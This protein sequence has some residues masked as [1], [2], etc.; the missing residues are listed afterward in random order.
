MCAIHLRGAGQH[1][2]TGGVACPTPCRSGGRVRRTQRGQEE[3][4]ESAACAT[5][6]GWGGGRLR[7]EQGFF[8]GGNRA[9]YRGYRCYRCVR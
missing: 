4:A 6:R 8:T 5:A 7:A 2:V 9:L 1:L 3:A